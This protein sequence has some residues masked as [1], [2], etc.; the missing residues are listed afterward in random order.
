[1]A[2]GPFEDIRIQQGKDQGGGIVAGR[3]ALEGDD[4]AKPHG[5]IAGEIGHTLEG[6]AAGERTA[7]G[8]EKQIGEGVLQADKPAP[9]FS[10]PLM[11][12][13][14]QFPSLRVE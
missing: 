6:T 4:E 14:K 12:G 5:F 3:A 10:S 2:H 1:L 11:V 9:A 13:L 8:D 7:E